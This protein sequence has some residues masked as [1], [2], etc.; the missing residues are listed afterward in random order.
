MGNNHAL[1]WALCLIC[2]AIAGCA[3]SGE[4]SAADWIRLQQANA[5]PPVIEPVPALIDTP[6]ATYRS[7]VQDP[8]SPDRIAARSGDSGA[9]LNADVLFPDAPMSGLTVVGYLGGENRVPVAMVRY[10]AQYRVVRVGDRMGER[11]A[12]VKE[13]DARGIRV[14]ISGAPDQWL[15]INKR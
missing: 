2:S 13:I 5:S 8:F 3:D 1:R 9:S 14:Q 12:L 4:K 10:G 11:E 6:P 15:P 7:K